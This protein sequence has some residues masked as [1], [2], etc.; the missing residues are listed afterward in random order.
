MIFFLLQLAIKFA[1]CGT[2]N[3][4]RH[5]HHE[6]PTREFTRRE[7]KC[8]LFLSGSWL[9]IRRKPEDGISYVNISNLCLYY[10]HSVYSSLRNRHPNGKNWWNIKMKSTSIR[11]NT[12]NRIRR[13]DLFIQRIHAIKVLENLFASHFT[14]RIFFSPLQFGLCRR[15]TEWKI[16]YEWLCVC[17]DR[18][19]INRWYPFR[20]SEGPILFL[21][22]MCFWSLFFAI[23][24][25]SINFF[26]AFAIVFI[27]SAQVHFVCCVRDD[28]KRNYGCVICC[29]TQIGFVLA[30]NSW[31]ICCFFRR[32]FNSTLRF[33]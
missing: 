16:A 20:M 7:K 32:D 9:E 2:I 6:K 4:R 23:P 33:C 26:F 8:S 27:I 31:T 12:L 10:Y 24:F 15:L 14:C 5:R 17:C 29:C 1:S 22:C 21:V 18:K 11:W 28:S 3:A 25:Q 30:N 13:C 19:T